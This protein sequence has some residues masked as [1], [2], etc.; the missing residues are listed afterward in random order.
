MTQASLF[1]QVMEQTA[2]LASRMRPTDLDHFIGQKHLVGEGKFLRDM[3]ER[4]TISS[5]IFWGPPG[6]V[7][8][9]WLRLLRKQLILSL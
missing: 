9:P 1:E 5:M 8:Q 7:R 4:D 3:I 2:P 6:S